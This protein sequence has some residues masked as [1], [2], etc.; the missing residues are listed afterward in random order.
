[1][2]LTTVLTSMQGELSPT[3]ARMAQRE[4]LF[5]E[6]QLLPGHIRS[7]RVISVQLSPLVPSSSSQKWTCAKRMSERPH[8][9]LWVGNGVSRTS[10]WMGGREAG[11]LLR[12]LLSLCLI[13]LQILDSSRRAGMGI[14]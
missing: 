3:P 13:L 14:P 7:S 1:M 12:M 2:R 6:P 4:A 5:C 11:L 9:G 8:E 10:L